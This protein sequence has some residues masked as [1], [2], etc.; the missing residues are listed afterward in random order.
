MVIDG[1]RHW[2]SISNFFQKN[3]KVKGPQ[4]PNYYI[5]NFYFL[6]ETL[7]KHIK[8]L[9]KHQ[10]ERTLVPNYSISNAK[11]SFIIFWH[12]SM[13]HQ[14]FLSPQVKRCAIITYKHCVFELPHELSNDL[15]LQDLRKLG[16]IRKL[17]TL[18]RMI[19]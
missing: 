9:R 10:S 13:F 6:Y 11:I 3:I 15:R 16:N 4:C 1:M 5:S 19:S 12:F 14:I 17:S 7:A 18:H 2:L 8:L